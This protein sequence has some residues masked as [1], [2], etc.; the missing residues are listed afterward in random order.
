VDT[1]RQFGERGLA[2]GIERLRQAIG[3]STDFDAP[4]FECIAWIYSLHQLHETVLGKVAFREKNRQTPAGQTL[5]AIEWA[6]T[7]VAH[8][9]LQVASRYIQAGLPAQ[10]PMQLGSVTLKVVWASD[11]SQQSSCPPTDE[12]ARLYGQLVAGRP[13][14]EPITVV[15]AYLESL[16]PLPQQQWMRP[17]S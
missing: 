9:L 10:L 2:Q 7:F 8:E 3:R 16:P 12:R 11:P 5:R 4:F 13:L 6:R 15:Q 14:L 1:P 17:T